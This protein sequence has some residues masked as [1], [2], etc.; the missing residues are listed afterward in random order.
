MC[1]K[2]K[3]QEEREPRQQRSIARDQVGYLS[4]FPSWHLC[5]TCM[6][7]LSV[8][9]SFLNACMG[10]KIC[11]QKKK[12]IVS[13][14]IGSPE[15]SFNHWL[16]TMAVPNPC[17]SL[18]FITPHSQAVYCFIIRANKTSSGIFFNYYYRAESSQWFISQ[19]STPKYGTSMDKGLLG[20]YKGRCLSPLLLRRCIE[21]VLICRCTSSHQ[22]HEHQVMTIYQYIAFIYI[23][24]WEMCILLQ[25]CHDA[26]Q[27][28]QGVWVHLD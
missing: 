19:K 28:T 18:A 11:F 23:H 27:Q 25:R 13:G 26:H 12:A 17:T 16:V 3:E 8:L 10:F 4:I 9:C 2:K 5:Q 15:V 6:W 24:S 14:W 1:K 21:M 20:G 22:A 7:L